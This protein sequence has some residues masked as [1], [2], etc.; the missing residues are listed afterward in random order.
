[1]TIYTLPVTRTATRLAA[2]AAA[3]F[4]ALLLA[5]PVAANEAAAFIKGSAEAGAAKAVACTACHGPN[6]N[7]VNPEWP[8][9][10]GQNAAYLRE[11][12]SLIRGAKR[13]IVLMAGIANALTDQDIADIAAYFSTQTPVGLEAEAATWQ[14][15][16][17]LYRNGDA[18]RGLP[19]C[20]ACHG[21]SA[22]GNPAAGYPALRAQHGTYTAKQLS[23][24]ATLARYTKDD[25]GQMQGSAN[26]VIMQTIASRLTDDDRHNLGSYLQGI[27]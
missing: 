21:P 23:D 10:A 12:I 11:Q 2:L 8:R 4:A 7:S 15:G 6:G 19:A 18:A 27:R 3:C 22:R 24:Y 26:S 9:L 16:A 17:K 1:M 25:K 14:A 20:M 13:N 5:Q